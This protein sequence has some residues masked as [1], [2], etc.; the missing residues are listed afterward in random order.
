MRRVCA[1]EGC[2]R[3]VRGRYDT[4][5][6][7]CHAV[8][9][10]LDEAERVCIAT[11]DTE[12]WLSAVDLNDALIAYRRSDMRMFRA[13]MNGGTTPEQWRSIKCGDGSSRAAPAT[14][15]TLGVP[16]VD[17]LG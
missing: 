10:E 2:D 12:H 5:S 7:L 14:T 9:M 16:C 1:R 17:G 13:A 3:T 15:G 11:G 8:R 4:C 6:F